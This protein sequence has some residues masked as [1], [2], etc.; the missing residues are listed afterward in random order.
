MLGRSVQVDVD[1]EG[2]RGYDQSEAKDP[3]GTIA[4]ERAAERK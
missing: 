2:D 3:S 1:E 4:V